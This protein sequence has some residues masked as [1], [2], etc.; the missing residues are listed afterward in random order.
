MIRFTTAMRVVASRALLVAIAATLTTSLARAAA[1][2]LDGMDTSVVP[3]NDFFAYANG[4][5]VKT[6]EIP[7]DRSTYGSGAILVELN[8]RRVSQLIE[9]AAKNTASADAESRAVGDFYASF[10]DEAAIETKGVAPLK[11]ALDRI[12]AITDRQALARALG[13]SLRADVDALNTTNFQTENLFGLW[14]GSDLNDP[15]RYVPFLLQGG[16][17]MPD[18]DYYVDPSPKMAEIRKQYQAHIAAMLKLAGIS[19]ADAKAARIF[20]LEQRMAEVHATPRASTL[21]V[22]KANN[23]GAR[24]L[25]EARAGPGLA[26]A[27]SRAAG[28][29][30]A[31][32]TSSSGSRAR[33]PASPRWWRASR[34]TRGRS[35]L[36]F[37][38][39]EHA[40]AVLPKAFVD[41]AFAFHGKVLTGTAEQ[42]ARWKR[43]V[44]AT[45]DALGE[46][47]GQALR[48]R[49]TSRPRRRRA[50][51]RWCATSSPRSA[52]A[53]TQLDWMAPADQGARPRRSSP[54]SRSASAI[55]DKWR[56]YSGLAGRPRRRLRQRPARGALRVPAQPRQARPARST[57][58][59]G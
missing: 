28:L 9:Q 59:S 39:I 5:W 47:V 6:T 42:R 44:D 17:G 16:L 32:A 4:T 48:Q 19:D 22:A 43:A 40:A 50:P 49:S 29:G 24:G 10:M 33:S 2:M 12:A 34:S 55:P 27:S 53:S 57:A 37:H 11:A 46:A 8:L 41:E 58:A 7:A 3:G 54:R 15:T 52:R 25:R 14:V 56:D 35:Y 1:P 21:D 23:P 45:N 38:A 30:N 13:E 36:A 31:A 26:D 51:R 20:D 18:R